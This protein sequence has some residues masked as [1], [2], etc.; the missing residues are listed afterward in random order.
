MD[1][2]A[3]NI[4]TVFSAVGATLLYFDGAEAMPEPFG[5]SQMCRAL[6]T[7]CKGGRHFQASSSSSYCWHLTA[8]AARLIGVPSP[9][10]VIGTHTKR[11]GWWTAR[12][13]S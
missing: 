6:Q 3:G 11:R 4:A 2:I 10:A 13:T 12:T 9:S 5:Q 7:N 1:E 8:A